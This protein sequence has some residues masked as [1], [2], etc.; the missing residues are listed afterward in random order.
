VNDYGFFKNCSNVNDI[1]GVNQGFSIY[2]SCIME[3]YIH[4]EKVMAAILSNFD[5]PAGAKG[6]VKAK[7]KHC[8]RPISGST[9][10]TSNFVK[11]IR[12]MHPELI[13]EKKSN[14]STSLKS[15]QQPTMQAFVQTSAKYPAHHPNQKSI[16]DAL[17]MFI[18]RDLMPLSVVDSPNFRQM[19]QKL[20]PRYTVPSRKH[21]LSK[22]LFN[23]SSSVQNNIVSLLH[24]AQCVCL[25][26][27]LWTNRQMRSFIGITGH[28]IVE[29]TMHPVMLACKRFKGR[30]TAENI[31]QQ[32]EETVST[33]ELASKITN[34]VTDNASNMIKAFDLPGFEDINTATDDDS[35]D[36]EMD[37]DDID[38]NVAIETDAFEY[39]P[40]RNPCFAHT[41]QLAVKDGWDKAGTSLARLM[42]KAAKL[43]SYVRKSTHATDFLEGEKRLQ[44]ANNTR[45]N[46]QLIMIRSI[47]NVP[48]EKLSALESPVKLTAYERTTLQEMCD[49]LKPFED[50]T[51][52]A[53]KE[54]A[55]S[56]SLV[57]P[58]VKGLKHKMKKLNV[59]YN[60]SLMSGLRAAVDNRL[61]QFEQSDVYV[62]ATVLDPRFKLRWCSTETEKQ[63][64]KASL[65][66]HFQALPPGTDT[67]PSDAA[68]PNKRQKVDDDLLDFMD[69]LESTPI[70][71]S[72]S[73]EVDEYLSQPCTDRH[74]DPLAYWKSQQ[75][76]C[77]GLAQLA[78]RFLN[79]PAS[80]SPVERLFSIAGNVFTPNRCALKDNTF[81]CLMFIR[82]NSHING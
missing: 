68:P 39:I 17:I 21:L 45:W 2:I 49:M 8:G 77:P 42:G 30:H 63:A 47:L 76:N 70:H 55:V 54:N 27:D 38:T 9:L 33:F 11:H 26:I 79:V 25:T 14:Q 59:K 48:H 28:L 67:P 20:D 73:T 71:P 80:S 18:A 4:S 58:C 69:E 40:E 35:G 16:T 19:L 10:T 15:E 78:I 65:L 57:V 46:S 13:L 50:A 22:L 36:D 74:S 29:W 75:C 64:I 82:C 72:S 60:C 7:C 32:Y 56:A 62:M 31:R 52:F 5:V 23:K 34:I 1:F 6:D 43:V 24:Q 41:L 37:S 51:M 44:Q 66:H 81:Q 61:T 3:G 53:Q 12:K